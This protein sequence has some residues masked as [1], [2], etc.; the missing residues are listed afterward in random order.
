M[1]KKSQSRLLRD[2]ARKE[3]EINLKKSMAEMAIWDDVRALSD[4]ILQAL[5]SYA[6]AGDPLAVPEIAAEIQDT[7]NFKSNFNILVM[8]L[9]A[10]TNDVLALRNQHIQFSGSAKDPAEHMGGIQI[11]Q[12]YVTIFERIEGVVRPTWMALMGELNAAELRAQQKN[13]EFQ[14]RVSAVMQAAMAEL[15]QQE[16]PKLTPEQDPTVVT[17]A[18]VLNN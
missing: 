13:P 18:V 17:D 10:I 9:K 15:N 4:Q 5:S 1:T 8:D 2:A 7:D 11:H 3:N 14:Q 12:Q 6:S 16:E